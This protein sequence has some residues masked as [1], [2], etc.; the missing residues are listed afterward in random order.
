VCVCVCVYVWGHFQSLFYKLVGGRFLEMAVYHPLPYTRCQSPP[1]VQVV[2]F[3]WPFFILILHMF[4][5]LAHTE[6]IVSA[7][8]T[9]FFVLQSKYDYWQMVRSNHPFLRLYIYVCVCVMH[10]QCA[11]H[12]E[13]HTT[14]KSQISMR[15]PPCNQTDTEPTHVPPNTNTNTR[16]MYMYIWYVY[17][18]PSPP[19]PTQKHKHTKHQKQR[20]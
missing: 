1:F 16:N 20:Q 4:Y 19:S 14:T 12:H 2:F 7:I 13:M 11:V 5:T 8:K 15:C 17:N 9:P 3:L 18:H 6:H 10:V